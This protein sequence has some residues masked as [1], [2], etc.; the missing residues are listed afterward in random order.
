MTPPTLPHDQLCTIDNLEGVVGGRR[1]D[2]NQEM[3]D[4]MLGRMMGQS[5]NGTGG[6]VRANGRYEF[7]KGP[8]G[9]VANTNNADGSGGLLRWQPG[10][11]SWQPGPTPG[12]GGQI[13]WVPDRR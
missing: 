11:G 3:Q 4:H 9:Y 13:H 10:T 2:I 12:I 6:W 5:L 1:R 7:A 8:G